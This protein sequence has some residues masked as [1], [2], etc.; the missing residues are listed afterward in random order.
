MDNIKPFCQLFDGDF[1]MWRCDRESGPYQKTEG[2]E[3]SAV[4]RRDA[5]KADYANRHGVKRYYTDA[6]ALIN[7]PE[8]DAIYI[9]TPPDVHKYYA[10]ARQKQL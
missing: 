8:I 2:F 4:M 7:D 5:Q 10:L 3:V 1:G 9:A 6:D